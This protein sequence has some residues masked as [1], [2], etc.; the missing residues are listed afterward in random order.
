MRKI[1]IW[2]HKI[3]Y[4]IV[5]LISVV[6]LVDTLVKCIETADY[7]SLGGALLTFVLLFTLLID[8]HERNE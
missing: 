2:G 7:S 3:A 5:V 6:F 1:L 8:Y 4:L